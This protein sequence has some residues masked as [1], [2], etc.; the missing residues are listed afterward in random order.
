MTKRIL[1][2]GGAGYIGSHTCVLLLEAGYQVVVVD[3]LCNSWS[4][5]LSRVEEL[6][7]KNVR[8]YQAD[9]RDGAKLRDLFDE[10]KIDAVIHFAGLKAVGESTQIPLD[11]YQNNVSGTA[12]LLEEM[13]RHG[14]YDIVFSSSCTVYGAPDQLP[15]REDFPLQA[16]NPY[17][18]T[19]LT[20]EYML[21]DLAASDS[22]WNI[23]I[24]RY[25]NPV[26]A[27]PSG[28]IGEDPLG[29]PD[30]LL[31][32]ITQVAVGKLKAQPTRWSQRWAKNVS[33]IGMVS[34]LGECQP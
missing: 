33:A 3:N 21:G 27:H 15:I 31:P 13:G 32:Y 5:S 1:I 29:V 8:F 23:S 26:G 9:L 16:V 14:V 22:S 19:K 25:F 10:E 30:N 6:T 20:I 2:T 24:L 17:G 28:R 4:E 12:N 18:Q 7:G 34:T 11:Y